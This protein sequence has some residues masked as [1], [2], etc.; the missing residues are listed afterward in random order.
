MRLDK[1]LTHTGKVT[2]SEGGKLIRRGAVTVDGEVCKDPA[3]HIDPDAQQITLCGELLTHA[4]F[5]YLMLNKPAGYVSAT[6]DP[7]QTTVL[8]L[9]P[10]ELQRRNLFPCGR[11][12]KDTVGLLL[13]TNDG[14]LAHRLLS[15]RHHVTKTYAF[16][17]ASP[18][19]AQAE[20]EQGVTLEDGYQTLPCKL[21]LSSPTQGTITV[22]E[23]KYH[24]I[25]RMFEAFDNKITYLERIAF[26]SIPLDPNLERGQYRPLTETEIAILQAHT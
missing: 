6:D 18:L 14:A 2:R 11:L 23:G 5:T 15:P 8:E 12:D 19:T 3:I 13:L 16:H 1:F 17:C 9:L 25:K 20:M 7:R 21:T 26:A 24:Q 4:Q 10:K 22:T